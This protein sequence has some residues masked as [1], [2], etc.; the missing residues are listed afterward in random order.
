MT[1]DMKKK[2]LLLA[3]AIASIVVGAAL[4]A[5]FIGQISMPWTI[6]SPPP[7]PPSATMSPS[8]VTLDMGSLA[9]GETKSVAPAKV[10]TLTVANGALDINA[11]LGGEYGGF[12]ALSVTVQLKQG[13]TVKYEAII[14]PAIVV[15]NTLNF[16]PTGWGG[17]SDPT[18]GEVVTCFVRNVGS[19]EGDLAQLVRWVPGA[20]VTAGGSTYTYPNTPFGYTYTPPETGYIAQNDNDHDSLQ[21][22]LV[23]P[24]TSITISS[25]APGTYDVYIGF[26]VTAGNVESM[27]EATLSI[28]YS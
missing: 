5:T 3:T 19:G 27:G 9:T 1:S 10:A 16:G 12:N 7:P 8:E 23:Y 2:T 4:A 22:V 6:T 20:S 15:S 11:L 28:S 13:D 21:L 17:W 18:K 24:P 26:T 25:V 14:Q